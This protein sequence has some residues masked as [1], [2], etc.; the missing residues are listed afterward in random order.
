MSETLLGCPKATLL[1][2][3]EICPVEWDHDGQRYTLDVNSRGVFVERRNPDMSGFGLALATSE[4]QIERAFREWLEARDCQI[5]SDSELTVV[6][7]VDHDETWVEIA[8]DPHHLTALSE[9]V[10]KIGEKP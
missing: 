9:A 5:T 8:A 4:A 1:R 10:C 2:A 7:N 6:K 3:M